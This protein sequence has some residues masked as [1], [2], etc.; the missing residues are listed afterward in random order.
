MK[1][2]LFYAVVFLSLLLIY[3]QGYTQEKKFH[4]VFIYNFYK[5][6]EWPPSYK[7]EDFVIG[8]LGNSPIIP[9]LQRMTRNRKVSGSYRFVIKKYNSL[10]EIGKCHMLFI[11]EGK[12][13][14]LP[15]VLKRLRGKSTLV[16]TEKAGLGGQ[17]SAINFVL[18][19]QRLKF[20]LNESAL[21]RANLKVS[22]T[23]RKLSI[24]I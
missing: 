24:L 1:K 5:D 2:L 11:P 20:E 22:G 9:L 21:K 7:G 23:L 16:I 3:N 18:I 12:S 15:D 17:G 4:A 19:N 13:N 14:L 8:V 6:I 10:N